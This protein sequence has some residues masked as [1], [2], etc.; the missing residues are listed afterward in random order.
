MGC[1][2]SGSVKV[3]AL[4]FLFGGMPVFADSTAEVEAAAGKSFASG[5][6]SLKGF[7]I[8]VDVA[9]SH[10]KVENDE[11]GGVATSCD[12][13]CEIDIPGLGKVR[14]KRIHVDPSVNVGY[15][16]FFN[17]WYLGLAGDISFGNNRKSFVITDPN[18]DEGYE[19]KIGGISYG[20]KAKGGCYLGKLD[21]VVYGIAGVKWR[22]VSY[23]R[24]G[25]GQLF[26]SK[27]KLKTPAFQ[28][29]LGFEKPIYK[30][31]SLSAEYEY[32]WR[33]SSDNNSDADDFS[34]VNMNVKQRFREHTLRIG[35]KCHF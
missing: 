3:L 29:G 7:F 27:A 35:V 13:G 21:S 18:E 5:I 4:V 10:S 28:L 16:H 1:C 20:L 33:S 30:G 22:E 19:A 12:D 32:S 9:Y 17:N 14:K 8:G 34:S 24:Y 6:N 31:L 15:S 25:D 26:D 23:T 11:T 2:V